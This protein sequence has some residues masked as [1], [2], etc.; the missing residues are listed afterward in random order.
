MK[1]AFMVKAWQLLVL[2]SSQWK[3]L[4]EAPIGLAATI[5]PLKDNPS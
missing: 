4:L 3:D 5:P 1:R 2:N